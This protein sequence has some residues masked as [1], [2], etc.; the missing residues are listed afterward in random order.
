MLTAMRFFARLAAVVLPLAIAVVL[1]PFHASMPTTEAALIVL[2]VIL[3]V[4]AV[5]DH[6]AGVLVAVSA[7]L[8]FDFFL[9]SPYERL[10][11]TRRQD[12]ET[13]VLLFVVGLAVTALAARARRNRRRASEQSSYL[14]ELCLVSR[15]MAEGAE[16]RLAIAHVEG[17]LADVLGLRACQYDP[18]PPT[19]KSAIVRRDGSVVLAGRRWPNLPGRVVDLPV[20]YGSQS[21]GR[22]ALTPTPGHEVPLE[23]R[24]VAAALASDVGAILAGTRTRRES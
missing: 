4:A 11:I 6:L 16:P 19:G 1:F 14:A 23:R 21:Y 7:G 15:M 3:G 10:S 20:E 9:T 24:L 22:F 13:T 8:L 2:V 18:L 5:A 12:I 17:L